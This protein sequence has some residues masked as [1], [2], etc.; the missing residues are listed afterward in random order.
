MGLVIAFLIAIL[1]EIALPIGLTIWVIKRFKITWVVILIG[2]MT[3]MIVQGIQIP[4]LSWLS[5]FAESTVG[6]NAI[7]GWQHIFEG[8]V[9][10]LTAGILAEITR[11][12]S[13]KF[14]N[15]ILKDNIHAISL[16]L[17][18]SLIETILLVGL[19]I[20]VSFITMLVYK[21]AD[22]NDLSLPEGLVNQVQ[23]LWSIPWHTP[24]ISAIERLTSMISHITLNVI[25][26]QVFL[27][28]KIHYLFYAIVWHT[29]LDALPIMMNGLN[30]KAWNIVI[31]LVLFS[32]VN[33]ILIRRYGVIN[34]LKRKLTSSNNIVEQGA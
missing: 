7:A 19:P 28:K 32:L 15:Q 4:I 13:F 14:I 18:Y 33:F 2:M 3:F 34:S 22:I 11:W 27:K 20:L 30:V 8:L 24:L 29:I 12:S 6:I 21:N 17:G 5:K 25:V 26:L 31:V 23:S 1:I 9:F 10:G 16:G